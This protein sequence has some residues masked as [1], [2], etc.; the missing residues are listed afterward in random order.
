MTKNPPTMK[1]NTMPVSTSGIGTARPNAPLRASTPTN[2][3]TS[4]MAP[5]ISQPEIEPTNAR[6]RAVTFSCEYSTP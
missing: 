3:T 2:T 4:R 6:S 1:K 5:S